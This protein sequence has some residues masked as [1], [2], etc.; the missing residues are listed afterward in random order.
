V[1]IANTFL[2]ISRPRTDIF[3]EMNRTLN[4]IYCY[5]EEMGYSGV[6]YFQEITETLTVDKDKSLYAIE[7]KMSIP[8]YIKLYFL[9]VPIFFIIDLIWLGVVAKGFFRKNLN[10]ILSPNQMSTGRLQSFSI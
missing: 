1:C 4:E 7:V 10:Y 9:T 5:A 2:F 6:I 8:F 3:L